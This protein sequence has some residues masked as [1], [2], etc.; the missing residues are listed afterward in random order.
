MHVTDF[1]YYTLILSENSDDVFNYYIVDEMH[2]LKRG[3]EIHGW[4]NISPKDG[5]P[6]VFINLSNCKD[7]ILTTAL[8]YHEM[9]HLS[10]YK[11]DGCWDSHE[12]EM[13]SFAENET[14]KVVDIIKTCKN[15][16]S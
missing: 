8:V 6:Y 1:P 13:I 7:D 3:D 15:C 9:M 10:S 16:K 5:K 12:E 11:F 14:Y 2:G 4:C